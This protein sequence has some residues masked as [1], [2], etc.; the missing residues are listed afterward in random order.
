MAREIAGQ[1]ATTGS[2]VHK[3][4]SETEQEAEVVEGEITGVTKSESETI[5]YCQSGEEGE[6]VLRMCEFKQKSSEKA[7]NANPIRTG[8]EATEVA[9]TNCDEE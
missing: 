1:E 3:K 6:V 2:S 7:R 5:A 8:S 4:Q 9:G